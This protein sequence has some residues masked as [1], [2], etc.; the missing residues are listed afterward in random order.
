MTPQKLLEIMEQHHL[1]VKKVAALAR[2]SERAVYHWKLGDYQIPEGA[3]ELLMLKLQK[4]KSLTI[5]DDEWC[6][7]E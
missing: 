3:W 5:M 2:V 1:N 7:T 4:S 6:V